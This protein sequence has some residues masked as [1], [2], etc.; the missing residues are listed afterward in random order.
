MNYSEYQKTIFN[1]IHSGTGNTA[2]IAFAG[3]GKTS[4]LVEGLKF[5]PNKKSKTL[6][7]A[8]NRSIAE[9]LR[10]RTKTIEN[11]DCF[12]FHAL[13]Y[14]AIQNKF[15]KV[16][17]DEYKVQNIAEKYVSSIYEDSIPDLCKTVSL[18]KFSLQDSPEEIEY[19]MD[20]YNIDP[21]PLKKELFIQSVIK[22]LGRCKEEKS[23]INY[24]DMVWFPFVHN[25]YVGKWNNIFVDECFPYYQRIL[26]ING[27]EEIGKIYDKFKNNQP[28]PLVKS[29]NELT[30][31]FEYCK[32]NNAWNR[33]IKRLVEV[34]AGKIKIK[35][36]ENHKFLTNFGWVEAK[37]LHPGVLIKT[38]ASDLIN[39][40][41]FGYCAINNVI[42]TNFYEE[43]YDIEVDKNHN[44]IVC[45]NS[46]PESNNG[47][48]AHNCQ[49]LNR[50]QLNIV[51]IAR[52]PNTR[53]FIFLDRLQAIYNFMGS[54]ID[55]VNHVIKRLDC[56]ELYL[57][58]SYRCPKSVV[59]LA[60]EF[61]QE[62]K[63]SENAIDGNV[64]TIKKD[65]L[66]SHIKAGSFILSRFNAPLI[67]Y[68][69]MLL[70]NNI[71]SIIKGKDIGSN[72]LSFIK[73]SK[74]RNIDSFRTY[75]KKWKLSEIEKLT[76]EKKSID[77]ILDK[78][79]C[80]DSLCHEVNGIAELRNMIQKL[81]IDVDDKDKVIL[82]TIH[83]AK[84]LEAN[85][86][87]IISSTLRKGVNQEENN[88]VYVA[89]TRS[90]E[91]LFFIED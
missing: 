43:V 66:L 3:S 42:P 50:A 84:G 73:K 1:D 81:F 6:V 69:M 54:N 64:Y 52:K 20:I 48:I 45:S 12:T 57:P 58:I 19:L 74:S 8:F 23:I 25:M 65:Q 39:N 4:S 26:T 78:Y 68:C 86:V 28:L 82:S 21:Y 60:K 72:L 76:K 47:L 35:C 34:H 80:L 83:K 13:G 11:I 46:S 67:T 40:Q 63:A 14:R 49:D 91:N 2:I 56:K 79:E 53:T 55:T 61:A 30:E 59:N 7:I 85:N 9:E 27:E 33:G 10:N 37:N 44:F 5:I 24:D 18:C 36:T 41:N 90:K 62:I 70:K 22:I 51:E 87:F 32:I 77:H 89:I 15:G 16:E 38:S 75:L 31:Q 71:P 88:L 29:F 17:I